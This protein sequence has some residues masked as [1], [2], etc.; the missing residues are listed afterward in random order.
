MNDVRRFLTS[1]RWNEYTT[2]P[3]S[4]PATCRRPSPSIRRHFDASLPRRN[5]FNVVKNSNGPRN[6]PTNDGSPD[7][8]TCPP[9]THLLSTLKGINDDRR[10][11]CDLYVQRDER[12]EIRRQPSTSS[13]Y[14][15]LRSFTKPASRLPP[16]PRTPMSDTTVAAQRSFARAS[17]GA[18]A[19]TATPAPRLSP[20]RPAPSRRTQCSH[21]TC[22]IRGHGQ[23]RNLCV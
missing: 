4:Q 5:I 17:G 11:H 14:V 2:T 19:A 12:A 10:V 1:I 16:P 20:P 13:S 6:S 18:P 15:R 8:S 21:I 9:Q 22:L 23:P 7:T 3:Q